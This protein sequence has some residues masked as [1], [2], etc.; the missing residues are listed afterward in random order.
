MT[1]RSSGTEHP[2][3]PP[4]DRSVLVQVGQ[5]VPAALDRFFEHFFD[6]LYAYAVVLLGD[7]MLAEHVIQE[8]FL[9]M[10]RAINRLDPDRDPTPWVFT[11]MTNVVHD[12]WRS[13]ASKMRRA[14]AELAPERRRVDRRADSDLRRWETEEEGFNLRRAL[15]AVPL[16]D[17]EVILL[18]DYEELGIAEVAAILE[19]SEDA[20]RQHHSRAISRL[21]EAYRR[22]SGTEDDPV[23]R[24]DPESPSDRGGRGDE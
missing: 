7:S 24:P 17:R 2:P 18:R 12:H 13:S 22:L 23:R 10:H 4:L 9:R 20:A 5:R 16:L 14:E 3:S 6:R 8:T 1:D 11:A 15:R 19:L 21:A